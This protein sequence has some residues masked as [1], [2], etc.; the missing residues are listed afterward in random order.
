MS[1]QDC[2]AERRGT[3]REKEEPGFNYRGKMQIRDDGLFEATAS[4][5][6]RGIG[7]QCRWGDVKSE[8]WGVAGG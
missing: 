7:T 3:R 8:E 5:R 1:A 2:K 4:R 6:K